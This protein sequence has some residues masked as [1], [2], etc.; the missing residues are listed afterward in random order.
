V[1][2]HAILAGQ[3]G[4]KDQ[5]MIINRAALT[6]ISVCLFAAS[7]L[8]ATVSYRQ[9]GGGG[10]TDITF[11]QTDIVA[12]DDTLGRYD[13][14]ATGAS[15]PEFT[16]IGIKDL[17]TA[18]PL[19]G[20]DDVTSA[21]LAIVG[22]QGDNDYVS[23]SRCTTNWMPNSAGD[24]Q[25]NVTGMH[26]DLAGNADWA[27]G[28]FSTADYDSANAVTIQW[29]PTCYKDPYEYNVTNMVKAMYQTGQNCGFVV[30]A[31]SGT[32][33]YLFSNNNGTES[34]RPILTIVY[35]NETPP[36]TY[37]LTVDSGSGDGSYQE[38]WIADISADPAPSMMVFD[39][40][41]GDTAGVADLGAGETT[42]TMPAAASTI[43]A[44]YR[45][46]DPYFLTVNDGSGSGTYMESTVVNISADPAPSGMIFSEW[47]GDVATVDDVEAASTTITMPG[48]NAVVTATYTTPYTLTVNSGTGSGVYP[49][50]T[51][52]GIVADT[53]PSGMLFDEWIGDTETID[54][55]TRADTSLLMPASDT[56]VTAS[57]REDWSLVD[58]YDRFNTFC[59]DNF[60]AEIEPLAYEMLGNTLVFVPS[61]E[62]NH[63]SQ[64]SAV[65]AFETNLPA[66][67]YIEYGQTASYG[68]D[69]MGQEERKYYMHIHYLRGLLPNTTYH[70]R[71]VAEDERSN[72]IVSTD[73][74]FTTATPPNVVYVP[75]SLG[76][77]PYNLNQSGK[78][79]LV[80]QDIVA[81]GTAF[82]VAAA[83]VTL[84]LG[85]HTVTYNNTVQTDP[86]GPAGNFWDFIHYAV[87]GVQVHDQDNC[88]VYNGSI[89]QG[90]GMNGAVACG[91]GYSPLFSY[92]SSGEVAGITADYEGDQVSGID[93]KWSGP[94]TIHHNIVMD[95]SIEITN[96]HAALY[97]IASAA[98][99]HHNL[100]KRARHC[101][102]SGS[103]NGD[104]YSNEMYIDSCATNGFAINH[105]AT[106][107]SECNDNKIFGTGYLVIGVGTVSNGVADVMVHDNY[108]HLQATEPDERFAEY[109]AQSGAYCCRITWGGDNI[110]YYDNYMITYGRDGGMVRGTWF[111]M[112]PS[113]VDC[114][115]RDNV[116]KAVLENME[117]DIQ[118]CIVHCGDSDPNDAPLVY[119]NNVIISN[120]CNARMGEDYYGAGCNAEFYDNTFLNEGPAR[121]DYRT[122]GVGYSTY[123]ST[124]H[125]FYDSI[126]GLGAGY[127][128]VRFDGSGSRD[129][130]VGWTLT[131]QTEPLADITIKDYYGIVVFD[132][133][134]DDSGVARTK[135]YQYKHEP[136]G[137]TY[138]TDHTV[139]VTKG[140]DERIVAVSMDAKKTIQVFFDVPG[141]ISGDDF[142]GQDDLD[143]ILA[144]WGWTVDPADPADTDDDG[145]VGQT[146]LDYVLDHWGD[147]TP[148]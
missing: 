82:K 3:S 81:D 104:I 32:G 119:E 147:G 79:Y 99:I 7:S 92:S 12:G 11:D 96:R 19:S 62:W 89:K 9:G 112:T 27:S 103:S 93:T 78:T 76:S 47:T 121:T 23:V 25:D 36:P 57:Y 21:T 146:D 64:T 40:W 129:F 128:E 34:N 86:T 1:C 115:Y 46:V 98:S 14:H 71:F 5:N 97:G 53:P 44:T 48:A 43:T 80:T 132:D 24:N 108:I 55:V 18:L 122:I 4:R 144:K 2:A 91:I 114:V 17:F 49:E 125:K 22:Y 58:W 33:V 135:L 38:G 54:M 20:P 39:F 51:L 141:D 67:G 94:N 61:G 69:T 143:M 109:G 41:I 28:N 101:G 139:T 118:G 148:P 75:G 116:V 85:G 111:H 126:F 6:L 136:S 133:Q 145:F 13:Y 84:D 140:D 95:R 123:R 56:E 60:G 90:A 110:Q 29:G 72:V 37:A 63:V 134:A 30:S 45:L 138:Y 137:K 117:S 74:A 26:A 100:I 65:I 73:R 52:V 142:V 87:Q 131:I 70:Y 124:G 102:I 106:T 107:G 31:G 35:T 120:F 8:A 68:S 105:Y 10:Y 66:G 113:I 83:N 127:D 42:Y 50:D 59:I 15:S 16:L 88:K 77:P 130:W